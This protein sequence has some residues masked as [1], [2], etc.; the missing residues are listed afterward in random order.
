MNAGTPVRRLF[1]GGPIRPVAGPGEPQAI[2]V[3]GDTILEAGSLA[4]CRDAL[5]RG[6]QEVDLAGA[7]L[8]PGFVDAHCHPLMLGQTATWVDVSPARA[9]DIPALVKLLRQ[10]AAV[11]PPGE[12]LRGYG[13]NHRALPERRHPTAADLDLAATDREI[14]V[15]NQ[16]GH[17][18]VLNSAGLAR[19]G[20]TAATPDIPG[21]HIG[22]Y[23]GG[24][25]DG[26]VMDASCDLLTGDGGVKLGRHG[27][28]LH[29]P[30]GPGEA[31]TWLADAQRA[32]LA[33]GVTSLVDAQ[34]SRRELTAYTAALAGGRLQVRVGMRII[35]SYLP[36]LLGLGLTGPFGADLLDVTGVKIYAD[37]TLGGWTAWFPCGYH[38]E[39]GHTGLL[40]HTPAELAG[41]IAAAHQAGLPTGTHAQSPDAI[42]LVVEAVEQVQARLGRRVRHTVE[43]CGLPTADL[44]GRMARAGIQP[45]MQPAHHASFGDGVLAAVGEELGQR[46]NPAGDYAAL[47]LLPALSSDAPVT[48]PDPLGA[49]RAAVARRTGAGVLLGGRELRL[50]PAAA[51]AAHT[52]G[53]ARAAGTADRVGSLEPGKLADLTVLDGDPADAEQL[54]S[55]R[56]AQTWVGGTL[57]Y[58]RT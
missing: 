43:H 22:R 38:G 33:A 19:C 3:A 10:Q 56:V 53:A 35:S 28:N 1:A 37:G 32:F 51:L 29:L 46:Y 23:P 48:P 42:G 26:L 24:R 14:Y 16:S 36:E 6:Y 12:P 11:L 58:Q 39:A 52:I 8:V 4:D 54:D 40:Y 18:G 2:A 50:D 15:M 45:V 9:P 21:G 49:I 41:I 17:G 31:A 57:R 34:V 27:P 30:P 47:G 25:P 7:T 44:V 55:V 5:G 20:I 13:Y